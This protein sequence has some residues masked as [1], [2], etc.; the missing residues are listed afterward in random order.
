MP[1]DTLLATLLRSLQTSSAQ[2][3]T[4][5][6]LSTASSLLS[7][8]R[9]P[10]NVTLLTAHILSAPAIWDRPD[11]LQTCLRV[12][13]VF[14]SASISTLPKNQVDAPV[15]QLQL[16]NQIEKEAWVRAVVKGA[17]DNSSR[18]KHLLVIG[19]VL[20]GFE[21]QGRN[22]L[23]YNLRL[24]LEGALVKATNLALA[25]VKGDVGMEGYCIALVL[26]H[27]F[28]LLSDGERDMIDYNRLLPVLMGS[29]FFS[30]E[31]FQ[32]GYFLGILDADVI[33][34]ADSKF[35]W[36]PKSSTFYQVKQMSSR[37]LIASMG[38]LSRL[39]AHSAEH[40]KDSTILHT[41]VDDLQ[42]FARTLTVQ[43]R[44]NKLSEVDLAEEGM[45][46]HQ[47]SLDT[48]LPELWQVLKTA[49]FATV[50]VLRAIVGRVLGDRELAADE[51][52]PILAIQILHTLRNLYFISSRLGYG[53]FSQYTFVSLT[54]IDILT[55]F[56]S[57][58][59]DYLQD[60]RPCELGRLPNHPLD[61][62]LDLYFLNTAEHF[63]L[64]LPPHV[65][66][67]LLVVAASPYLVAGGNNSLLEIFEAAHSVML[68]VLGAPQNASLTS[69]H[70]PSYVEALFNAFP[71]NLS[72]RQFRFAFKTLIR[73]TAPPSPLSATQLMLPS[74]LLEVLYNRAMNAPVLPLP[75]PNAM[76]SSNSP[77]MSSEI[78]L[79][80][81]AVL[82][83]AL[84][85][86][87]PYLPVEELE[88][89]LPLAS[90]LITLRTDQSEAQSCRER[91]WEVI[92]SGEMD[93][94]RAGFCVAWWSTRGGRDMV[95][96]GRSPE[97]TEPLLS[98]GLSQD[99][100][101]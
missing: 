80:E 59:E 90:D 101:S 84:L 50:V 40:C 77:S 54:A 86:S 60:I 22:G 92:S 53:A 21:F 37:P 38:P 42:G 34:A 28:E 88:E 65:N 31:G 11:G 23:P 18:W 64:I 30:H 3:D 83:L 48:T 2:Q 56:P 99:G 14:H 12:L 27:T 52:A 82:T 94:S 89:W 98:G 55:K 69:K 5:R 7:T 24:T 78:Q 62:C 57:Q 13:G 15:A 70:L 58:A 45:Y 75:P 39:I 25:G 49:M 35:N 87:L 67:N 9:N 8:L 36:S 81:Q 74:T 66:E 4:P 26:N 71:Q 68:A 73:I 46:L 19:G 51:S 41:L 47:E 76:P 95:M 20:L 10:L 44:Q 85:D 1:A 93:V 29:A 43:W 17:D 97:S 32:S 6:L 72:P 100:R 96:H 16:S 91:F 61:R 79:S 63:A 33:Q